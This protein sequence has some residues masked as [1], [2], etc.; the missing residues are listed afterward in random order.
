MN[1]IREELNEV[2][3]EDCVFYSASDS[4]ENKIGTKNDSSNSVS[5]KEVSVNSNNSLNSKM[6]IS[7]S[8]A[9]V[10]ELLDSNMQATPKSSK[11]IT[12][13]F[14][15]SKMKDFIEK[16]N[17]EKSNS[18]MRLLL[19]KQHKFDLTYTHVDK[20]DKEE[21]EKNMAVLEQKRVNTEKMP[22]NN[23]LIFN[24]NKEEEEY[25]KNFFSQEEKK[26]LLYFKKNFP[27]VPTNQKSNDDHLKNLFE[28]QNFVADTN[29]I[30]VAVINDNGKYIATGGKSGVLKIWTLDFNYEKVLQQRKLPKLIDETPFKTYKSHIEDIIDI[31]WS[32]KNENLL[33]TGSFDKSVILWDITMPKYIRKFDH[34]GIISSV[35]FCPYDTEKENFITACSDKIIRVWSVS[36]KNVIDYINLQEYIISVSFFPS[37]SHIIAGCHNGKCSVFEFSPKLKYS[38]SFDCKNKVGKYSDGRKVNS[39]EFINK[40]QILVTTNDSRIRLVNSSDGKI[41]QKY[42]GCTNFEHPIRA[43]YDQMN[44]VVISASDDGYVYFWKKINSNDNNKNSDFEKMKPFEND[45]PMISFFATDNIHLIYFNIF[46]QFTKYVILKSVIINFSKQGLMQVVVNLISTE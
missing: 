39:I 18:S 22:I 14:D 31:A 34:P 30:W 13:Y 2:I 4:E 10:Q 9:K 37:S 41:I 28:I 45:K 35:C 46:K 5:F 36:R 25:F 40:T 3:E 15:L 27:A 43:K 42:R 11:L 29:I 33:I 8:K 44:D 1:K 23:K 32:N 16:E 24:M 17:I 7:L 19:E 20:F 38:F 21:V 26:N 6:Q 12:A